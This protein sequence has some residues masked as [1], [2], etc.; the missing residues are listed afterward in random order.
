MD[1]REWIL[2]RV[3]PVVMVVSSPEAEKL[4][5]EKNGLTVVDL[6]R[7]YGIFHQLSGKLRS[8]RSSAC[9]SQISGTIYP[10][11]AQLGAYFSY[12]TCINPITGTKHKFARLSC[13]IFPTVP[14]R[15]VGEQAYRIREFRVRFYQ[16]DMMFQPTPEV[17]IFPITSQQIVGIAF[18]LFQ[19]LQSRR[20]KLDRGAPNT[21]A[22]N[23]LSALP[24]VLLIF[25]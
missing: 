8:S 2:E 9:Q 3:T 23:R 19:I 4:C 6:L 25:H 14:V 21:I 13:F 24:E 22:P 15:T 10:S 5:Q 11:D 17:L 7:P 12:S 16:A 18:S 1:L 20:R